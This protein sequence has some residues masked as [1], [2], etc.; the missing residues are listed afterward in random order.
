MVSRDL[1]KS[2]EMKNTY[3]CSKKKNQ[4]HKNEPWIELEGCGK[5]HNV[6]QYPINIS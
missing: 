6:I 5:K 4:Q 2:N 1:A 3:T